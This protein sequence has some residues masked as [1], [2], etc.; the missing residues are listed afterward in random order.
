[1][2]APEI[3]GI[4]EDTL[5]RKLEELGASAEA[6][7]DR[8]E[9]AVVRAKGILVTLNS[10]GTLAGTVD[11]PWTS[12]KPDCRNNLSPD[13][14]PDQ[15]LLQAVVRAQAWLTDLIT[16]RF[17]SVEQLAHSAKLHPKV[18][19]QALRLGFLPAGFIVATLEGR[20]PPGMTLS[21]I[22]ALPLSWSA[23][24]QVLR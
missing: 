2:S 13:P 8:I 18:V 6:V 14:E 10:D 3:E 12:K 4:I 7:W 21:R 5:R 15:K 22:K 16:G 9:R 19:R 11:I 1:M 23:Q 24:E 20:Q 17:S